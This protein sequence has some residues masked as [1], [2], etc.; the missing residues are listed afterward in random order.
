[1][2]KIEKLINELCPDGVE[3]K[4]LNKVI[5]SLNTGL[6]PRKFFKLNT[7]DA[8]NYYI[9][10][11]EIRKRHINILESTDLINDE[12]LRLCNN[13]S[14]LE[15]GDVLF[16]GTG[17]IGQM[18][19]IEEEPSNW[20]IKEGV[21]SI[22]PDSTKLNSRFLMYLLESEKIK[23]S[24]LKMKAGGTVQ[25]IPM[26]ALRGLKIPVPPLEIQEEIVKILDKFTDYVTELTTE[27]TLRQKQYNYYRDKLFTFEGEKV[28]WKIL[29][30][31]SQVTKL[32]GYEFTKYVNYSNTGEIIAL[33]GLN[34]K[35]GK[36]KLDD[37]KY[38][39]QS[40]FSKLNRSKLFQ[41]DMLFTYVGTVGEVALVDEDDK[42]YLAPNVALVR[43]NSEIIIPK[44][45]MYYFQSNDFKYKQI[46]KLMQSS[47]MK[48]LTMEK[49]RKF[50][51]PI[52]S[53]KSQNK[54]IEILDALN[55]IT[56]DI[57]L[58][59][60]KEIELRQKQYEYYR[61]KMLTFD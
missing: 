36:L 14:N 15:I 53:I 34:V 42:Y 9:T 44:F 22:K 28:E 5:L 1:M 50:L 58:G 51:I 17:T 43:A 48:N 27:L 26:K 12:A 3:W 56:N 18:V 35:N 25:S 32:A 59:L 33:R 45:L 52:P 29:G 6:N 2:N 11:R 40:D 7:P 49:I 24:Y 41:N 8:K 60:P 47:S 54:I 10:I 38:I 19:V 39:D 57:N 46:E 4:E 31:L 13:R 23:Q 61:D 37:L 20:N 21:Y 30:D 55:M 16:S